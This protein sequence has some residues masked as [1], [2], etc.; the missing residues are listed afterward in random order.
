[1]TRF[2]S[3]ISS[4]L[5]DA[6]YN[7]LVSMVYRVLDSVADSKQKKEWHKLGSY[8]VVQLLLHSARPDWEAYPDAFWMDPWIAEHLRSCE[9]DG[10]YYIVDRWLESLPL[11]FGISEDPQIEDLKVRQLKRLSSAL[12]PG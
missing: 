11:G 12:N 8:H 2:D 7:R 10:L 1:M 6:K 9:P 5:S 4:A 3:P